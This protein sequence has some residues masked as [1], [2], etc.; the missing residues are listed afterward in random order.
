MAQR[1]VVLQ[2]LANRSG[3]IWGLLF[4]SRF[5]STAWLTPLYP[6]L[7]RHHRRFGSRENQRHQED[8]SQSPDAAAADADSAADADA[9]SAANAATAD[10]AASAT[11]AQSQRSQDEQQQEHDVVGEQYTSSKAS[12][13]G[14]PARSSTAPPAP[15]ATPAPTENRRVRTRIRKR[16]RNPAMSPDYPDSARDLGP[17]SGDRS[18]RGHDWSHRR[19]GGAPRSSSHLITARSIRRRFA[20]RG[21]RS[22]RPSS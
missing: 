13:N 14:V 19:I 10:V 18:G 3:T 9:A 1:K 20:R 15:D 2:P 7:N 8:H 21:S 12:E 6:N 5:S 22:I 4:C 11:E 17:G 16:P